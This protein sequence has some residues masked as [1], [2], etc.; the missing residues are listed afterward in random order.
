MKD[1]KDDEIIVRISPAPT[2]VEVVKAIEDGDYDKEI[3]KCI[4]AN[5]EQIKR[6]IEIRKNKMIVDMLVIVNNEGQRQEQL[7]KWKEI[8]NVQCWNT[9]VIIVKNEEDYN[10]KIHGMKVK[11]FYFADIENISQML[12][13]LLLTRTI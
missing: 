11:S 12:Y 13:E 8:S 3:I 1:I 7:K 2:D 4:E 9:K 6:N 10:K 5:S